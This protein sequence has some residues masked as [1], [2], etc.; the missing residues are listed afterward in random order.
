M[1]PK[2]RILGFIAAVQNHRCLSWRAELWG[3]GICCCLLAGSVR[4]E[5]NDRT[6]SWY[7]SEAMTL[8]FYSS[9]RVLVHFP[10]K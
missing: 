9:S 8:P 1:E 10:W 7:K 6:I 5:L 2:D 3:C 4:I